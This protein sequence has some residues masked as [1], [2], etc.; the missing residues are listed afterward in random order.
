MSDIDLLDELENALGNYLDNVNG[1]QS[2]FI[3]TLDGHMLVE[4]N[5]MTHPV[6]QLV[7]MAGSVLGISET[8]ATQ[9]LQQDLRDNIIIMDKHILGLLKMND[10]EDSL[11]LGVICDRITN[12]GL[13]LNHGRLTTKDIN[14][15]L[16]KQN[17]F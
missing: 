12:L 17:F 6:E 5:K 4:K 9:I 10:N 8:L 2:V 13:M 7:P 16:E 14:K 3:A 15:I 1:A 11:F